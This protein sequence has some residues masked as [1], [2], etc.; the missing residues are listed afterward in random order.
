MPRRDAATVT[1]ERLADKHAGA[2]EDDAALFRDAMR[3]VRPIKPS[4]QAPQPQRRVRNRAR[5]VRAERAAALRESAQ[6]TAT[7][8]HSAGSDLYEL[9]PGDELAFR[10]GGVS[11]LVL[12]RLR[13]GQYRID[14]ELDLH[15]CTLAQALPRL[16]QFLREAHAGALT[17]VRIIHGKGLRSGQRGPVLKNAVNTQLRGA[18]GVLAFASARPPG[19]GTGATLVLLARV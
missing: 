8:E 18:E 17:C 5:I 9:Q 2:P 14:A 13:R 16:Q 4:G 1:D 19:G 6:R 15:G 10:R 11:E 3:D 12:R 7:V